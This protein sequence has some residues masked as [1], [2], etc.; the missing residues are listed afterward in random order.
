MKQSFT[1]MKISGQDALRFLQG[2]LTCDVTKIQAGGT[3]G[4][5]LNPKGRVIFLFKIFI[6]LNDYYLLLPSSMYGVAES[7]LKK[8]LP[9][10]KANIE[11]A[12]GDLSNLT[13]VFKLTN[14][15]DLKRAN[16]LAG[17]PA[18]YPE[19]SGLFLPHELNLPTL[20]AVS[21]DKG[22][23]TGQ[24]ITARMHYRGK[25]K[26]SLFRAKATLSTAPQPGTEIVNA[27][28]TA[29]G[30]VV[31]SLLENPDNQS[32]QLLIVSNIEDAD[33]SLFINNEPIRVSE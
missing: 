28:Q 31:D 8:Y 6:H 21:F 4:A 20:N 7:A 5:H 24:E 22:C 9:F 3:L 10:F 27:K 2:Q 23:Y 26:V 29:C 16:L 19:T 13:P 14:L 11:D 32:Y 30:I 33:N 1:L 17:I 18:I 12:S 25:A 15:A